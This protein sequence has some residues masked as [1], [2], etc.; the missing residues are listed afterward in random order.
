[1]IESRRP[2][3][4]VSIITIF[5]N[6]PITFFQEALDSVFGQTE[7]RWELLLVDDGSTDASTALARHHGAQRPDQIRLLAHPGRRRLG[8]GASRNLGLSAV[9]GTYVAFL[10]ADD[11]YLP[12]K[13]ER[14]IA[15]LERYPRAAMVYGPT[16][17][18]HSWT[19]KPEDAE[20]D[21]VRR[22]GV[23]PDSLIEPPGLVRAFLARRADTPATCAV[24]VRRAAIEAI[25]GFE[26]QF[27]DLNEDQAF[28]YKLCLA[29]PVYVEAR[30][31]DLYRR[32]PDS[33]CAALIRAGIHSDD[34][35][36]TA[37][38]GR[39]LAWLR[40]YFEKVSVADAE[41]WS[42]L[43]AE[44]APFDHPTRYALAGAARR[45]ARAV[46]PR[47]LRRAARRLREAVGRR[48]G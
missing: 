18:W 35:T 31:W 16:P 7:T 10:D 36:P 20:R 32:H 17:H 34:Y 37:P 24:L 12:Q 43:E 4:L 9:A 39:F 44:L 5:H 11:I 30:A 15:T 40:T 6:P 1:M 42:L 25:G 45:A 13:L 46:L 2:A 29:Q 3:P 48:Q 41:L 8:T 38:R 27:P 28:F 26:P 22:L 47:G 33:M 21:V 19:G 14:Q 23:A